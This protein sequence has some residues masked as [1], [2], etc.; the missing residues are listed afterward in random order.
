LTAAKEE[1]GH[2]LFQNSI[3]SS[4]DMKNIYIRESYKV[5]NRNILALHTGM[6]ANIISKRNKAIVTGTPGIGKSLFLFYLLWVLVKEGKRV[7]FVHHPY[8]IYYDGQGGVFKVDEKELFRDDEFWTLDLWC[9]FDA[10]QKKDIHL[11]D[12]R[13]D[14][15]MFVISSS[16]RRQLVN[17]FKKN[18]EPLYC[19]MPIWNEA[20]LEEIAQ[21][22]N[23]PAK[24]K[25]IDRFRILG[26]IPRFLFENTSQ[27]PRAI[28]EKACSDV[29]LQECIRRIGPNSE[30][31][32]KSKIIHCLIH[33]NSIS[34][35]TDCSVSFASKT[36]LDIIARRKGM[37]AIA[38]M[39]ELLGSCEGQTLAGALLGY[40][41]EP[42][43]IEKLAEGGTFQCRKLVGGKSKENPEETTITIKPSKPIVL[44]KVSRKHIADQIYVPKSK[45][46]TGL[47]AWIPNVGGFQ[48]TIAKSHEINLKCCDDLSKLKNKLF[49]ILHPCSY[50]SFT[51]KIDQWAI[52]IPYPTVTDV[53]I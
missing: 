16:P 8:T 28:L 48:M 17:D 39:R 25:W 50:S 45:I 7:V 35:Y 4:F 12:F 51:K 6:K 22:F 26:G 29:T 5:I 21:F 52:L 37:E 2:L 14:Q 15:C 53:L 34:P 47:D 3:P 44:E 24:V 10:K 41:F 36:A 38:K 42:Y 1:N 18:P 23:V 20:E 40:I 27:E 13:Y 9:L 11:H 49:W 46:Y 30:I 19:Y 33:I 31:T 43:A 32:G